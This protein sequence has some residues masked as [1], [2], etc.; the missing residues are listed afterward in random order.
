MAYEIAEGRIKRLPI[1]FPGTVSEM[2]LYYRAESSPSPA[3]RTLMD[4]IRLIAEKQS[5]S[6]TERSILL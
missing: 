6:L 5:Q 2:G 3:A 4:A 1:Q